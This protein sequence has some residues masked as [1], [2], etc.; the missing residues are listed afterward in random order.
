MWEVGRIVGFV[1]WG[2]REIEK[3]VVG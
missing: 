1:K 2:V 3:D